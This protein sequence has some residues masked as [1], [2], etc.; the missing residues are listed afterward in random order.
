MSVSFERSDVV[1]GFRTCLPVAVGVG[2]YGI[3]F[4]VLSRQAGLSVAEAT[5]MSA[6]VLAGASQLIAVELWDAPLPVVAIVVTT[7]VVNLR[8]VLMGASLR[9]WF[10]DLSPLQSYGSLFFVTDESWALSI[11]DLRTGS[12]RGG[13]LLGAGLSIWVLWVATTAI[14]AAAGG[15]VGNPKRYG[16]DFVLTG[17]FVIIAVGLWRGRE[18]L[19]PW[20][21][22]AGFAILGAEMLPGRWYI[23]LGGLAGCLVA[24]IRHD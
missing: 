13:F 7:L 9:P 23:L 20:A 16:L 12:G 17:I 15:A 24:V 19:A 6:T 11:A 14:G 1:A 5:L 3:A 22:A 18:D 21:V 2:G 4:G 10:E 8:Y